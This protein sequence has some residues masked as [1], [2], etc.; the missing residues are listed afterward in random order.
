LN[1]PRVVI[2]KSRLFPSSYSCVTDGG[3]IL[4]YRQASRLASEG[5]LVHI[6]TR[7]ES[8]SIYRIK[9]NMVLHEVPYRSSGRQD[10]ALR[11]LEEGASFVK[12]V[13]NYYSALLEEAS[14]IFT[15]HWTSAVGIQKSKISDRWIHV[16]HL[17]AQAKARFDLSYSIKDV[18]E[19]ERSIVKSCSFLICVSD[20]ESHEVASSY[21]IPLKN[22]LVAPPIPSARFTDVGRRRRLSLLSNKMPPCQGV[23]SIGRWS[24][25]KQ[26][27]KQLAIIEDV[28]NTLKSPIK[29]CSVA[30]PYERT[31]SSEMPGPRH[32]SFP[33]RSLPRLMQDY[34]VFLSRAC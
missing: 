14:V 30:P 8:N 22:I 17:L 27:D 19:M 28:A 34:G 13:T 24:I 31:I 12:S 6:I 20:E 33:H 21:E 4:A 29:F 11:D 32:A 18:I 25:Q 15:H 26:M 1:Q 16:P 9:P 2:L 3:T 7:G 5:A 10:P 23:L